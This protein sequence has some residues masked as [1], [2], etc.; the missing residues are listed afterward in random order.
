MTAN[1]NQTIVSAN[2][3]QFRG[4]TCIV[5]IDEAGRGPVLGPMVYGAG[6]C[7]S[8][9]ETDL[10]NN[11]CVADSKTLT[12][13][14]RR[15]IFDSMQNEPHCQHFAYILEIL[16]PYYIST[17][18]LRRSKYNLNEISHDTATKLVYVDTVGQPESYQKKLETRFPMV[19]FC[20]SKKAD[21][22]YPVVSAASICA[23]VTRDKIID[24]WKCEEFSDRAE[25]EDKNPIWG[26]GYPSDPTTKKF[27]DE[28]LHP[29]F[30]YPTLV[31]FS[32]ATTQELLEKKGV[33]FTWLGRRG[34]KR[35][36]DQKYSFDKIIFW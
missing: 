36:G 13:E 27:M 17:S 29:I 6:I 8:G 15:S 32:W 1:K 18:M 5:G 16:S 4:K 21:S 2:I 9:K 30:G 28:N 25:N 34:Q 20:V 19:D 26:S 33:K 12:D 35:S 11:L 31:R 22:L 23:K 10:A 24:E 3:D 7:L 14:K